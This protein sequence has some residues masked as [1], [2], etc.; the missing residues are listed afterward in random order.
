MP[1]YQ[2]IGL[3]KI[4]FENITLINSDISLGGSVPEDY[5]ISFR[6]STVDGKPIYYYENQRELK[7]ENL[8]AGHIWLVNCSG[9]V[10]SNVNSL[11]IFVISSDGVAVKNS[12][13]DGA[14]INIAFSKDCVI[15]NNILTDEKSKDGILQYA[16]CSNNTASSN[17]FV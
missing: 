7:L 2:W 3:R 8:N 16:V 4:D 11:G 6:N 14:G 5:A 13:V 10:V 9:S 12:Q 1:L 15:S 17:V